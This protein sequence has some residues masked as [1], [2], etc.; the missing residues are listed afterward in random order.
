MA[1]RQQKLDALAQKLG[2]KNYNEYRDSLAQALGYKN[3]YAQRKA[4]ATGVGLQP[5]DVPG[6][7]RGVRGLAT[8]PPKPFAAP[9]TPTLYLAPPTAP[10]GA[11]TDLPDLYTQD[12]RLKYQQLH[13]RVVQLQQ[14]M[15]ASKIRYRNN[16]RLQNAF[17]QKITYES[18]LTLKQA[19]LHYQNDI[20]KLFE[21]AARAANP[22]FVMG[23]EEDALL[24]ELQKQGIGSALRMNAYT[25]QEARRVV[26][27]AM[28]T[29][30]ET[31]QFIS[32]NGVR[33]IQYNDGR[34]LLI[35]D[36]SDMALRSNAAQ[37]NNAATLAGLKQ[38]G[39]TVVEVSDGNDC[40]WEHHHDPDKANG[41]VVTLEFAQAHPL[42]HPNCQ[43]T[44]NGRP[45]LDRRDVK[46]RLLSTAAKVALVGAA[47]TTGAAIANQILIAKQG[48]S[49]VFMRAAVRKD[50]RFIE[51]EKRLENTQKFLQ[52]LAK[53][54]SGQLYDWATQLPIVETPEQLTYYFDLAQSRVDAMA[55][56][57][58][59]D[60]ADMVN[61][62]ADP[63]LMQNKA[64]PAFVK[65]I[66]GVDT[67]A[68]KQVVGDAFGKFS[69]YTTWRYKFLNSMTQGTL[70]EY[71][72]IQENALNAF[73]DWVTPIG[74]RWARFSLP[75]IRGE[76]AVRWAFEDPTGFFKYT[77]TN[78]EDNVINRLTMNPNGLL[79]AGF[80]K[81]A[82]G[83]LLPEF[84]LIG[85]G[86]LRITTKINRSIAA[87]T[88]GKVLSASIHVD[89]ITKTPINF[90]LSMNM[91]LRALNIYKW[92][93]ILDLG[94]GDF[95]RLLNVEPKLF[96]IVDNASKV[97]LAAEK[98]G[99]GN[100]VNALDFVR[101]FKLPIDD[102]LSLF[103]LTTKYFQEQASK[104]WTL[105]QDESGFSFI[106]ADITQITADQWNR[107]NARLFKDKAG[108]DWMNLFDTKFETFYKLDNQ[109]KL[110]WLNQA[111]T[112]FGY[113]LAGYKL[114]HP[115]FS[116]IPHSAP[117][118]A[119]PPSPP[120]VPSWTPSY[121][122]PKGTPSW[123]IE[124]G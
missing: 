46:N 109:L 89:L 113:A 42:S 61:Q 8:A 70:T 39:V 2:F 16:P 14:D 124:G 31:P 45:E 50:P 105:F 115:D 58:I 112:W 104:I 114:Q 3:Y 97:R 48:Q 29:L 1:T 86:P 49:A 60:M 87:R 120:I 108:I 122:A 85:R 64:L 83:N 76:R 66:L 94:V 123:Q 68:S 95:R 44:F 6:Q 63:F 21:T 40:G 55:G 52:G 23:P 116:L 118:A 12:I 24:K 106:G 27:D 100:W 7:R 101:I 15:L 78:I 19:A 33:G 81:D 69:E 65:S 119:P 37:T 99:F 98:A 74:P 75:L 18:D 9:R 73:V 67:G 56:L 77:A 13:A 25:K 117:P 90:A 96:T 47:I 71:L 35:S 43:R 22:D 84:R 38:A 59:Q 20:P 107:F 53:R 54:P 10:T 36:Y 62:Y 110:I 28:K 103:S 82:N 11:R 121:A 57:N 41:Q 51:F 34:R 30:K 5:A 80:V 4:R 102:A 79:R 88:P 17:V 91:K 72:N 111:Y 92:Q 93:D 26:P 32:R